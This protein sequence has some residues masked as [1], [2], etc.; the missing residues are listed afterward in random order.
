MELGILDIS[1]IILF[2]VVVL[3]TS[4]FKSRKEETG[5]DYFL[6]SRS[7][8]WPII[9]ISLIAANISSEQFV[10]MSGQSAGNVGLAI[11]SYEWMAA[12]TLVFVAFFFLPRF[13]SSGIYTIPEFLEYRY[14]SAA[15][16][17]MAFY[18]MVIY[19]G[20]TISA[21]IYSG[22]ITIYT[23]FNVDLEMAVWIIGVIAALYTTY[24][25]L[26]AVAWADVFQG[27]AL[28]VGGALVLVFGLYAVGGFDNFFTHNADKLHMVLPADHP[29]LPWT[30]LV[31]GLWIPNIYYWGLNQYIT[32][33]TLAAKSLREG[34][35]GIIFAA[36]IKIIIPFVIVFPGIMAAQLYG[37]SMNNTDAAY[38]L[39]IKN[40]IP[41]GLKGFML[42][43]IAGAVISSLASML[44]SASTIFTLD[45]Y[46]VYIKKDSSQK[47]LVFIGRVM[48]LIF[49]VLGC[50]IAPYLGD[51][52][53]Q[54]IFTYIQEFQGYIS[55]GI[56]AA[57]VFGIIVKKAPPAAGVVALVACVPVYGFLQ[58][59]FGEIAF[60]NRMAITFGIILLLMTVITIAKPLKEPKTLPKRDGFDL[61]PTP[62]LMWWGG[63]VVVVTL[64][65]YGV[66]W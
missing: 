7:L 53:F 23:I 52:K 29:V 37:D 59:Q 58:W 4:M 8:I 60:L 48:T 63:A 13:L 28:I 27:T 16:S 3:G 36:A 12:I 45:L 15:R 49:V 35:K 47:N 18:T 41:S 50:F 42:A 26:K 11:A 54:G 38:P 40:L 17:L 51:P 61:A 24:G 5:E 55:P 44:N 22:A 32:Q 1:V 20:V 31:I 14:N 65:L 6:A 66:F 25:G 9:G 43:A 46:K 33:R 64:I 34:Q 39:L 2:F 57:F 56:L 30:A 62:Q 10:G 21:V 19:V